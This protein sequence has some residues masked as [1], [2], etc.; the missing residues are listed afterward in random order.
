[1][2]REVEA[3]LAANDKLLE[4]ENYLNQVNIFT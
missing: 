1:M 4:E 2:D 3:I